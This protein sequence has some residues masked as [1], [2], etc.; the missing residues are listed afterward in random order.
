MATESTVHRAAYC[1]LYNCI[2]IDSC[3][4]VISFGEILPVS[5]AMASLLHRAMRSNVLSVTAKVRIAFQAL[6]DRL[7][8]RN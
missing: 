8:N 1:T 4:P 7:E 2:V 5:S 3:C 6:P